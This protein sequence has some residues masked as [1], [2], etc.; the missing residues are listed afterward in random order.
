LYNK[1]YFFVF[2]RGEEDNENLKKRMK[3]H[4]TKNIKLIENC[5]EISDISSTKIR[6]KFLNNDEIGEDILD[7]NVKNYIIENN[8]FK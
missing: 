5:N 4:N 7:V 6:E 2:G 1:N 8:L 3:K